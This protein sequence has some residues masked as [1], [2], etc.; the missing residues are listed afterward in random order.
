MSA[1]SLSVSMERLKQCYAGK[2][3]DGNHLLIKD[4]LKD[5]LSFHFAMFRVN[6]AIE[7]NEITIERFLQFLEASYDF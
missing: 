7:N 3:V 4:K 5:S 1:I 6:L 2:D